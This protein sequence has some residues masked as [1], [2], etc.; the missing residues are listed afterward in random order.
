[1]SISHKLRQTFLAAVAAFSLVAFSAPA[2][3]S[4][5]HPAQEMVESA[6][7]ELRVVLELSLIH[8]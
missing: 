5:D 6:I 7:V 2:I 8:I 1:M 3:A 4:D